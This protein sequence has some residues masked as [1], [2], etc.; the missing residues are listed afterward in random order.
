MV[1]KMVLVIASATCQSQLSHQSSEYF[2]AEVLRMEKKGADAHQSI[3]AIV[4]QI[5]AKFQLFFITQ[6][7]LIACW[8]I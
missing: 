2:G 1:N 5:Y 6:E 3:C 4:A 7:K 8:M